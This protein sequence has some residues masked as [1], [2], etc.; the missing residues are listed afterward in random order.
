MNAHCPARW[1]FAAL[2][3]VVAAFASWVPSASGAPLKEYERAFV[4]RAG[5][6]VFEQVAIS[7]IAVARANNE[8]V[9]ELA[10]TILSDQMTAQA[11]LSGIAAS[12]GV[13]ITA[14]TD[15]AKWSKKTPR[16]F[17]RD[18]VAKMLTDQKEA[19]PLFA[20]ESKDGRDS[21]LTAFAR[22]YLPRV[23][24]HLEV[25]RRLEKTLK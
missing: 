13:K 15:Q 8:E 11:I 18:Y 23:Q 25:A 21:N 12:R 6:F 7:E 5:R 16:D 20:K 1:K 19:L 3:C 22:Q 9:K 4:E 17:D 24:Q 14:R 10:K 2:A